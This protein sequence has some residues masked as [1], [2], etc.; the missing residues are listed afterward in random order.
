MDKGI[1]YV[2][3]GD[4]DEG[5]LEHS[6]SSVRKYTDLPIIIWADNIKYR[7]PNTSNLMVRYFNSKKYDHKRNNNRNSSLY[8]LI[9]LKESPFYHIL[10]H[11]HPD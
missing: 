5:L 9:A 4:R 7:P 3:I 2:L 8:R 1:V 10:L 6:I 11:L